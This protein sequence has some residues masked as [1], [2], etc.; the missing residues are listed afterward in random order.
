MALPHLEK[1]FLEQKSEIT[2]NIPNGESI[3]TTVQFHSLQIHHPPVL[4]GQL[5]QYK[6]EQ[7]FKLVRLLASSNKWWFLLQKPGGGGA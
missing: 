1:I 5:K 7:V 2:I 4:A 6:R 3:K